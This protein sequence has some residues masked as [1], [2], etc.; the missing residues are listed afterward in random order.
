M[1]LALGARGPEFEPPL[2]P[3]GSHVE[4]FLFLCPPAR[5]LDF[6]SSS[7][8]LDRSTLW[9]CS[10]IN[11]MLKGTR[12]RALFRGHGQLYVR[13]Y[14]RGHPRTWAFYVFGARPDQSTLLRCSGINCMQ[15]GLR[16]ST[17]FLITNQP[18]NHDPATVFFREFVP[19]SLFS[20]STFPA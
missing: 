9:L 15:K 3:S 14:V 4:C 6:C 16:S 10:G 11:C 1:I 8:W 18:T 13:G 19:D 7:P 17:N 12:A 2:S 20:A 5:V